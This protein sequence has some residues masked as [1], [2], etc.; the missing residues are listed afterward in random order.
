MK[1]LKII[2]ILI[3]ILTFT[4]CVSQKDDNISEFINKLNTQYGKNYSESDFIITENN[5]TT[6]SLM[7]DDNTL[8]CLYAD[9]NYIIIQAT[10]TTDSADYTTIQETVSEIMSVLCNCS[11]EESDKISAQIKDTVKS[12]INGYR[13]TYCNYNCGQTVIINRITD[14]LNTNENPTLKDYINEDEISRP[15]LSESETENT[16]S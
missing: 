6:Y 1:H 7:I 4:S 2:S 3:I 15:V 13:I 5:R 9:G 16:T 12:E 14:E 10:I 11:K 8:I